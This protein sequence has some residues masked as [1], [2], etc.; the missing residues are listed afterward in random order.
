MD[1]QLKI[2]GANSATPAYGRHPTSQLLTVDRNQY[3]IDCGEGTQIQ[4]IKYK[5]KPGKINHIFISHLHGD[6]FYGLIGLL[7]SMNLN[8]RENDLYIYGPPNLADIITLQMKYT[9]AVFGYKLH[10]TSVEKAGIRLFENKILT[11]DTLPLEHRISCFGF[12]FR[13]KP[14][15]YRI[16][17]DKLAAAGPG[18]FSIQDMHDL[19][20]GKDL[21]DAQGKLRYKNNTLTLPPTPPR[22]YAYCSDTRFN[23]Q[24]TQWVQHVDLLYHEATFLKDKTDQALARYHSTAE[25]AATIAKQAA[26]KKL[27]IGHY[28][29][30]Y[31]ELAPFLEE[32][33]AVFPNTSLAIEG[34]DY[35]IGE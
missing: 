25:Q 32:A 33:Q 31:K 23:L 17:K 21:Y 11:V 13:E 26:V 34:N 16:D 7:T 19:K 22:S 18:N 9:G 8:G 20:A 29:S 1:F 14:K 3:L 6:H 24:L 28:S 15:P 4:L 12:L 30:R 2:L 10:F 5:A 35:L 27:I